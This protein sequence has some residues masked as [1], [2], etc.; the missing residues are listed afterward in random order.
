MDRKEGKD[1]DQ[2]GEPRP[3]VVLGFTDDSCRS[4]SRGGPHRAARPVTSVETCCL[5]LAKFSTELLS[6]PF[7]APC[8]AGK[9]MPPRL[10]TKALTLS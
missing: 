8:L 4:P 1:T 5:A 10:E 3:D 7:L 6:L 9:G 2:D